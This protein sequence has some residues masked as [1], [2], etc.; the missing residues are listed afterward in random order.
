MMEPARTEIVTIATSDLCGIT[1]GRSVAAAKLERI[2]TQGVGWVPAN[3]SLTPF[4]V[5]ADPNP[6]GS[7]GDLRLIPDLAARYRVASSRAPTPFHLVMADITDLDGAPWE[8]C[9]RAILKRTLADFEAETGLTILSAFEQEFQIVGASWRPAPAFSLQALRRCDPFAPELMAALD[10]AGVEPE[11]FLPEYGR[12]QFEVSCGP[13]LG[14]ASA[15]RAVAMR[16]ITREIAQLNGL[17]ATFAPKTSEDGVG[18]GVH[19]HLSFRDKNGAPA[20]F[21]AGRPGRLSSLGGAFCAGVL[22]RLPAITALTAP[23]VAS[24]LRLQPHHWSAAWTWLGEQDREATLRICPTSSLGGASPAQ[25]F[26]VE[27]R[28]ADATACPHL[29]LA[30]VTRAGLEGVRAGLAAPP[31][32]D[33]DPVGMSDDERGHLGLRRLPQS[34]QEALSI[35]ASDKVVSGWFPAALLETYHGLKRRE[36]ALLDGLETRAMLDRY[37]GV[38]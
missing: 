30:A 26:N 25:Q 7:R 12:D 13:A 35:M 24:Y 22:A 14:E 19:L 33:T 27:Y 10:E 18:N 36:I 3:S 20:L 34:L 23:S 9:P 11:V 21:D 6:W 38:Y 28:A 29:V 37:I 16:E 2:A 31:I 32:V 8:G 17:A 4:D 15:D 5:I 1:R